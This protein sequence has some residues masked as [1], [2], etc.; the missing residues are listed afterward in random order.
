M[1]ARCGSVVGSLVSCLAKS[2]QTCAGCLHNHFAATAFYATPC[3]VQDGAPASMQ[4]LAAVTERASA[5]GTELKRALEV[6]TRL[7]AQLAAVQAANA[8]LAL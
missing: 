7:E 5:R 1:L 6:N 3:N 4:H 2:G 8:R